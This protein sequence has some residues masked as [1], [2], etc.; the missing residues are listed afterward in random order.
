MGRFGLTNTEYEIMEFFWNQPDQVS[1]KEILTYFNEHVNKNWKKQTLNTYLFN[2]Q[3]SSVVRV[4]R[5]NKHFLYSFALTRDELIHI[6]TKNI[7][8]DS[9]D[10]SIGAFM[11]AYT[12]GKK[13]SPEDVKLIR[14]FL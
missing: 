10:D 13:L 5:T 8:R 4:D 7:V 9:F 1:F 2:L 11:F 14:E 12:G 3:K 6:W